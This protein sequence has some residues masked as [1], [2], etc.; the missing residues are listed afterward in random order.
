[1][2]RGAW[3]MALTLMLT[4]CSTREAPSQSS[5]QPFTL[6][7]VSLSVGRGCAVLPEG[8]VCWGKSGEDGLFHGGPGSMFPDLPPVVIADY[9][10]DS[11]NA[12]PS[13]FSPLKNGVAVAVGTSFTCVL[14]KS[15]KLACGG[16][17]EIASGNTADIG[18][19]EVGSIEVN[20]PVEGI[21]AG[22]AH[23]CLWTKSGD[24]WCWGSNEFKQIA[25]REGSVCNRPSRVEGLVRVVQLSAGGRHT[26]ALTG[27]GKVSC[28]GAFAP[29]GWENKKQEVAIAPEVIDG[30]SAV[31]QISCGY[32]HC[33]ALER[34]GSASCWGRNDRGQLGDG[35]TT[36]SAKP[37]RVSGLAGPRQ[38]AA[39]RNLTCALRADGGVSCWGD[40]TN[41]ALGD[42]S[43]VESSPRPVAVKGVN[44]AKLIAAGGWY[45]VAI[46][47]SG[48]LKCW[49]ACGTLVDGPGGAPSKMRAPVFIETLEAD[50]QASRF[51][52]IDEVASR[53]AARNDLWIDR[54][55]F[56]SRYPAKMFDTIADAFAFSIAHENVPPR[57]DFPVTQGR[58][59][60]ETRLAEP[61]PVWRVESEKLG[62]PPTD[63]VSVFIRE[64]DEYSG[65]ITEWIVPVIQNGKYL[66]FADVELG[67]QME[68]EGCVIG[69]MYE[70]PA[71]RDKL[72]LR[73]ASG[74]DLAIIKCDEG[75][76]HFTL[77][78]YIVVFDRAKGP[79]SGEYYHFTLNQPPSPDVG[80]LPRE[81]ATMAELLDA[82]GK[83]PQVRKKQMKEMADCWERVKAE[84][85]SEEEKR[86]RV[87]ECLH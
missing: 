62:T 21:S 17:R 39:G 20:A 54:K 6:G 84:S 33:C 60:D 15:G 77:S 8:V 9:D 38:I 81:P 40:N 12:G 42:G 44:D 47:G 78:Q 13:L 10:P 43:K 65:R 59:L 45:A 32:S 75:P 16:P 34:D 1:M 55:S 29:S 63:E 57:S 85:K 86:S 56:E 66:R 26:C 80:V 22:D 82:C 30:L 72:L 24:S 67:E 35:T 36:D 7:S 48:D 69:R 19:R 4:C 76:T 52:K 58:V 25:Q 83:A 50:H 61:I 49:G 31:S 79:A 73:R 53:T 68:S 11:T 23:V 41:G 51:A 5:P 70:D 71:V 2:P 18:L 14:R 87:M 37:V 3:G 74:E 64:R 46:E 27:D 28:W